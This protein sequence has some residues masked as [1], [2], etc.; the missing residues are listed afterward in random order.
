MHAED[1]PLMPE[2]DPE[3]GLV[4]RFWRLTRVDS[5]S[6]SITYQSPLLPTRFLSLLLAEMDVAQEISK[7]KPGNGFYILVS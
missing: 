2:Q 6:R 7:L 1:T 4:L 5:A 3:S